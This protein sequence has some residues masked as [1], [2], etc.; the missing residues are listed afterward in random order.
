MVASWLPAQMAA[1]PQ[2]YTTPSP[3]PT[4]ATVNCMSY[5]LNVCLV[6]SIVCPSIC[7]IIQPEGIPDDTH[8]TGH[9][10]VAEL[11][12]MCGGWGC[13]KLWSWLP[14]RRTEIRA[15]RL[16]VCIEIAGGSATC[17]GNKTP[18]WTLPW[19]MQSFQYKST[20]TYIDIYIYTHF[21][22]ASPTHLLSPTTA[23]FR[24][25]SPTLSFRSSTDEQSTSTKWRCYAILP[26]IAYIALGDLIH[27]P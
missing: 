7:P 3:P 24:F 16:C 19:H 23:N 18:A 20:H 12:Y 17:G 5:S 26:H 10:S 21:H 8:T 4:T 11:W 22:S 1:C 27:L 2:W 14:L 9:Q 13:V 15:E 6:H 25:F